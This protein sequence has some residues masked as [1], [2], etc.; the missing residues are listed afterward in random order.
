M[1][2]LAAVAI[3]TEPFNKNE[4]VSMRISRKDKIILPHMWRTI[5]GQ[6]LYQ[7]IVLVILTYFGELIFFDES[8]NLIYTPLRDEAGKP[9]NRMIL[10][11]IVFHSF[12]LMNL[13]NQLNCRVVAEDQINILPSMFTNPLFFLIASFE[14]CL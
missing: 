14:I 11:T 4:L 13:F 7:V 9:T 8:F 6:A 1:D 5:L 2:I 12:I 3:C 10:D